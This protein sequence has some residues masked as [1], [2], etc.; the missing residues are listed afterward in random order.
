MRHHFRFCPLIVALMIAIAGCSDSG[1]SLIDEEPSPTGHPLWA[2]PADY[3]TERATLYGSKEFVLD[4]EYQTADS[5]YF[6]GDP[7]ILIQL[8]YGNPWSMRLDFAFRIDC[9]IL[10]LQVGEYPIVE[11]FEYAEG[12]C[13]GRHNEVTMSGFSGFEYRTLKGTLRITEIQETPGGNQRVIGT[14][15][16]IFSNFNFVD[17]LDPDPSTH[18]R[19]TAGMNAFRRIED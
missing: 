12:K 3:S 10:P 15:D 16:A 9:S 13:S 5:L 19:L 17:G 8:R 18:F 11:P 14:V 4:M 1:T 2:Y 6:Q 7:R